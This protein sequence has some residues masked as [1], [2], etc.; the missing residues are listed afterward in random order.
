MAEEDVQVGEA[1][2]PQSEETFESLASE[3]FA[4]V[5]EESQQPPRALGAETEETAEGENLTPPAEESREASIAPPPVVQ[6]YK[7]GDSVYD[8]DFVETAVAEAEKLADLSSEVEQELEQIR[9]TRQNLQELEYLL[10]AIQGRLSDPQFYSQ[11]QA[12]LQ[13]QTVVPQTQQQAPANREDYALFGVE[14]EPKPEPQQPRA[15]IPQ[16]DLIYSKLEQRLQQALVPLYAAQARQVMEVYFSDLEQR[17]GVTI[18]PEARA[19]IRDIAIDRGDFTSDHLLGARENPL[20]AA[21]FQV[22]GPELLRQAEQRKAQE[23]QK[24]KASQGLPES[25]RQNVQNLQPSSSAALARE[26]LAALHR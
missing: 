14:E 25:S 2:S 13:G 16:E 12:L 17:Y 9:Q 20:Q 11:L 5:H 23:E 1:T 4:Q 22:M 10:K 8:A 3:F 26:F 7:I 15:Q 19:R 24:K 18:P 6:Q 21:F